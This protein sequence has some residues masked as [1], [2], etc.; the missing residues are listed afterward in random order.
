MRRWNDVKI[1]AEFVKK[2]VEQDEPI[3]PVVQKLLNGVWTPQDSLKEF[4]KQE[5]A[6][7][8]L[9]RFLNESFFELYTEFLPQLCG[10]DASL[11]LE[12]APFVMLDALSLREGVLLRDR[13]EEKGFETTLSYDFSAV[14]SETQFYKDKIG[15]KQLKNEYSYTKIKDRSQFVVNGNEDLVWSAFPD[16][17]IE[18]MQSGR[19]KMGSLEEMYEN[20]ES[21][22]LSV[23]DRLDA[24]TVRVGSDHGYAIAAPKYQFSPADN[25]MKNL[26]EV[27]GGQRYKPIKEIEREKT[28]DALVDAGFLV[29]QN[30]YAMAKA[31]YTWTVR[32][33]YRVYQH[34]GMSLMECITP[35][36]TVKR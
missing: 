4:Y 11:P 2:L 33:K 32:G 13:L 7:A 28:Q 19:V 22:L 3:Q 30:G 27:M 35:R 34:G 9:E 14:P 8:S 29:K 18:N 5:E 36:L 25:D 26:R 1:P 17:E 6:A 23:L 12:D 24:D 15:L 20:T 21:N 10:Q 16:A 31:R